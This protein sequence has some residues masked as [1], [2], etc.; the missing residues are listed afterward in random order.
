MTRDL[1]GLKPQPTGMPDF[2]ASRE[3]NQFAAF[4]RLKPCPFKTSLAKQFF[5]SL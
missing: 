2:F 4:K 1:L 3:V 5:R